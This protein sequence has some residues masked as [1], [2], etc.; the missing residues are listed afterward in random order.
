[1][2]TKRMNVQKP[3]RTRRVTKKRRLE[4]EEEKQEIEI[5]KPKWPKSSLNF[6]CWNDDVAFTLVR[7][8]LKKRGWRDRGRLCNPADVNLL[9][10]IAEGNLGRLY[11][12]CLWWV[13]EDDARRL[14]PLANTTRKKHSI[15][16]FMGTDAA[17]TKVAITEQLNGKDFYPTSFVLP[18]ERKA[19][20]KFVKRDPNSY[21]ISKPRNDYAG[22]GCMVYHSSQK[23]FKDIVKIRDGK[24]FVVQKYIHNPFLICK[25]KFHFRMYTILSGI[26]PFECYLYRGGH[27]LFSTKAY[28]LSKSTLAENFDTFIHLTN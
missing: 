16:T 19:L 17:V 28:T 18:K 23:M 26:H 5:S 3:K 22:N 27:A 2:G 7:E 13:H 8:T 4:L 11:S 1:M 6:K 21:W 14:I 12:R 25:Y 10:E 15:A 9:R 20:A 24:N